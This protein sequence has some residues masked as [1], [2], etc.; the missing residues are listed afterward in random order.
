MN[1]EIDSIYGFYLSAVKT[2]NEI[3]VVK[4]GAKQALRFTHFVRWGDFSMAGASR[5]IANSN[6]PLVLRYSSDLPKKIRH[7][8][9]LHMR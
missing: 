3:K 2:A 9:S 5:S 1:G 4:D 7:L 8:L 6:C